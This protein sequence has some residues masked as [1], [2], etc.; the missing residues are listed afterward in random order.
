MRNHYHFVVKTP[1]ADL[2]AGMQWLQSTYT[3]RLNSRH[4]LVGHVLS[5]RYKAQLIEAATA[6][7]ARLV[8]TC[9]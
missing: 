9:I 4:G 8:I 2:V 5:G 1:N 6:I 3:I 7:C